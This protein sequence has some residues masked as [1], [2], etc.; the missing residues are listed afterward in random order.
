MKKILDNKAI[1]LLIVVTASPFILLEY[2]LKITGVSTALSMF[3]KRHKAI[4]KRRADTRRKRLVRKIKKDLQCKNVTLFPAVFLGK[5]CMGTY[6]N[7]SIKIS[8]AA[9]RIGLVAAAYHEDRHYQQEKANPKCFVGYISPEDDY[10]GYIKQHVEKDARRYSYV[11]TMR[12]AKV[13]LGVIKYCLFAPMYRLACHPWKNK[14][15]YLG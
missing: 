10:Q 3:L 12:Y 1:W 5:D 9:S 7:G 8:T 4:K 11:M 15:K 14:N 2:A 13:N 6:S